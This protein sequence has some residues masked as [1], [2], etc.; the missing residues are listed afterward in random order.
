MQVEKDA[1]S[2]LYF[3]NRFVRF[4]ELVLF[5]IILTVYKLYKI[6]SIFYDRI[7]QKSRNEKLFCAFCYIVTL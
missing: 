1:S 4:A 2:K 6:L 5:K 7:E 3:D